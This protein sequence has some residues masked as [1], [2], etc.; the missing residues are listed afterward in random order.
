MARKAGDL[1]SLLAQRGSARRSRSGFLSAVVGTFGRTFRR[2]D[3][4]AQRRRGMPSTTLAMVG[5]LGLGIGYLGG[6]AF[7][8]RPANADMRMNGAGGRRGIAPGPVDDEQPLAK[9][10]LVAAG[11]RDRSAALAAAHTLQAAPGLEKARIREM[12]PDQYGP[13]W[14][15][16]VYFEGPPARDATAK[17]LKDVKAPDD[18][19]EDY[20]KTLKDWP[21]ETVVR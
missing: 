9:T 4:H 12:A 6:N 14:A 3:P 18:T 8:W 2:A 11:Y 17:A 1:M 19:F 5:L 15:L 21:P 20:R 7:P 16:L 13:Q 10:A